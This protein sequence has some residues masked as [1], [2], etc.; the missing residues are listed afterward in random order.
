MW[1]KFSVALLSLF[2]LCS[3]AFAQEAMP[4][5]DPLQTPAIHVTV[6]GM[7]VPFDTAPI[8]VNDRT[9]VPM[10]A[11][12]EALGMAV[13][14]DGDTQTVTA[15]GN[16]VEIT[17]TIGQTEV[18]K[19]TQNGEETFETDQAPIIKDDRTLVPVRFIAEAAS[20]W[21]DWN[22]PSRTVVI[23]SDDAPENIARLYYEDGTTILYHGEVKNGLPNGKGTYYYENGTVLCIG[24]FSD[25]ETNGFCTVYG[26]DFVKSGIYSNGS[27]VEE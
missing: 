21:V 23:T 3:L 6:N 24:E 5:R 18:I 11:I 2:L 17:T 16:G 19:R 10:R 7:D 12:F 22:M 8:I 15:S 13:E 20:C 9:M 1:K 14:W 4:L 27:L 25:G 26:V